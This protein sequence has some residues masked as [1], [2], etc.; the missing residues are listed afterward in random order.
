MRM[1]LLFSMAV[2]ICYCFC[3]AADALVNDFMADALWQSTYYT[4]INKKLLYNRNNHKIDQQEQV[5]Q[6]T[7]NINIVESQRYRVIVSST[8]RSESTETNIKQIK[9]ALSATSNHHNDYHH[10][11]HYYH[12]HKH[13][14]C[15]QQHQYFE[16]YF[17]NERQFLLLHLWASYSLLLGVTG[18]WQWLHDGTS[19]VADG[20]S[21]DAIIYG[22]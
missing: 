9:P 14:L 22:G 18:N 10:N 12:C 21:S 16:I 2:T 1:P 13:T 6:H 3:G 7:T 8:C 19:H 11:H 15:Q 4:T 5:Q 17:K 20:S